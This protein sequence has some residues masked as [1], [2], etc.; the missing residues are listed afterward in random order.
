MTVCSL[1]QDDEE[2]NADT[3]QNA[4]LYLRV[5]WSDSAICLRA[6]GHIRVAAGR[7]CLQQRLA[8]LPQTR[9]G[10]HEHAHIVKLVEKKA[11]INFVSCCHM[12]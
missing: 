12:L 1:I 5:L 11:E 8:A 10:R 4:W 3:R 6:A 9:R 7:S 2:E